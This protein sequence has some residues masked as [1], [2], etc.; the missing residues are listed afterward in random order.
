[1]VLLLLQISSASH[2]FPSLLS[3]LPFFANIYPCRCPFSPVRHFAQTLREGEDHMSRMST[4]RW[5]LPWVGWKS[6]YKY[7]IAYIFKFRTE[8]LLGTMLVEPMPGQHHQES[9]RVSPRSDWP[10]CCPGPGRAQ[11]GGEWGLLQDWW[12][13]ALS[14][15]WA[16]DAEGKDICFGWGWSSFACLLFIICRRWILQGTKLD[17]AWTQPLQTFLKEKHIQILP[18]TG[19]EKMW[20]LTSPLPTRW[21]T[22]SPPTSTKP[23]RVCREGLQG[24]PYKLPWSWHFQLLWH[25]GHCLVTFRLF[26]PFFFFFY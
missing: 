12:S 7:L 15:F 5:A 26:L 16:W 3:I 19:L 17:E 2:F 13:G 22:V 23:L 21:G 11:P 25:Q 6:C 20:G 14:S 10:C 18:D 4:G 8:F 24:L 1:M 9:D